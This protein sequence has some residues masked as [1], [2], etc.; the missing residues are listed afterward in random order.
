MGGA[1]WQ[2][3]EAMQA[4]M[5]RSPLFSHVTSGL[6]KRCHSIRNQFC[7]AV[8]D[9]HLLTWDQ[10]THAASI[11]LVGSTNQQGVVFWQ[12]DREGRVHDGKVMY[13]EADCHRSKSK[14]RHPTW[15]STFVQRRNRFPG[16]RHVSSHCFFGLHRLIPLL[17][18]DRDYLAQMPIA[19]VE[20]EKT[21]FV[22][23][24]L[25]PQYIWLASGGLGEVQPDKFRPLRGRKVV[26]MPD[27]DTDGIAFKRWSDAAREV[28]QSVFW[29]D[30]PPIH[31]S[32]FLELH[33]TPE[34]KQRKIDLLDYVMEQQTANNQTTSTP[35]HH[36]L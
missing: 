1:Y 23:S 7:M 21:A 33:A 24:E 11:Y 10:M 6:W 17:K 3:R 28:M 8:V 2:E 13:Y 31:V 16:A 36:Q 29:E 12:I 20:S 5:D 27:T 4:E 34:Q 30:S 14:Q 35:N 26:M 19:L 9:N 15:V 32:A 22:L 18:A 25:Y